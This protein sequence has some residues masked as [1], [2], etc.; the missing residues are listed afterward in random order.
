MRWV[1]GVIAWALG[2]ATAPTGPTSGSGGEASAAAPPS[3][4]PAVTADVPRVVRGNLTTELVPEL[5]SETRARLERYLDVRRADIVGW[6]AA[7]PGLFV[8]TRLA[9]VP[10]LHRVDMP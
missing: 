3:A 4:K 8:L 5:P 10:Q 2:C 9:N 6:D 1:L 7:G